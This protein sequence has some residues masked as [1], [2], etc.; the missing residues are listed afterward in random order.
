MTQK[1]DPHA[2][3]SN[4]ELSVVELFVLRGTGLAFTAA[5]APPFLGGVPLLL[6]DDVFAP[7]AVV[8]S[9]PLVD[10]E[11]V[12]LTDNEADPGLTLVLV[13]VLVVVTAADMREGDEMNVCSVLVTECVK[14]D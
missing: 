5:A 6:F 11:G 13:V 12:P 10:L 7:L 9:D 14:N 1:L 4:P 3:P 8:C 2:A